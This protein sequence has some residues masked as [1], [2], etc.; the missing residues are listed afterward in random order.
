MLGNFYRISMSRFFV[1]YPAVFSVYELI[2]LNQSGRK[3][4][5]QQSQDLTWFAL[6]TCGRQQVR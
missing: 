3:R 6:C 2:A 1:Q 5:R 4:V